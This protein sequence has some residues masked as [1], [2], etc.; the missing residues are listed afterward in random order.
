M[1]S[2]DVIIIGSGPAGLTAA[3]YTTRAGL[4]T[5]VLGGSPKAGDPT[6]IPGGQLMV[7]TAVE[8]Y[9]GF[10]DGVQGPD[11]MDMMRRQA[12]RFGAEIVDT[13]AMS[14]ETSHN[15]FRVKTEESEY[16]GRAVIISTGA[17]AKW[18]GIPSEGAFMNRGVTA[19]AVCDGY[20]FK[21]M[22][23]AV[24]GGG[25]TAMEDSLF[26]SK[27]CRSVKILHRRGEFRASKIMQD[28]VL[29]A[30]NIE[31]VWNTEILEVIGGDK[32]TGVRLVTHPAGNPKATFESSPT[33]PLLKVWELPTQGV[34]VAIGHEPDTKE[35]ERVI[36]LD[37]KGYIA[38]ERHVW[39]N[40]PGVFAAGDAHDS[41][42]RQAVTAAGFGCMAAIEAERWLA[43][44]E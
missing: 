9:P 3:I 25:D 7:T 2:Y 42:Y 8:N 31:V 13:N 11:L 15:P 26:L 22:D 29:K 37:P 41:H 20:F 16:E 43:Q 38:V 24:V 17:S 10:P 44:Q 36:R 33:D 21:G 1:P 12:E 40:V 5:L 30:A 32:V 6:R 34:F 14:L 19:C 28:R 35:F 23:V 4:K 27:L 18:L 39:T